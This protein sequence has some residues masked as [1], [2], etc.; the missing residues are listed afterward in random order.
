MSKDTGN[1]GNI[2]VS[3]IVGM[4]ADNIFEPNAIFQP[5]ES[6]DTVIIQEEDANM[7]FD[8]DDRLAFEKD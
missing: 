3:A 7:K 5:Q 6:K 8:G 4:C 2:R 1:D